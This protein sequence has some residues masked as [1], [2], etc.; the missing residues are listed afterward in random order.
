[1]LDA[2]KRLSVD[3]VPAVRHMVA[4]KCTVLWNVERNLMWELIEYFT[5][6]E[7]RLGI[8]HFFLR[9][10]LMGLPSSVR[11]EKDRCIRAVYHRTRKREGSDDIRGNAAWFIVGENLWRKNRRYRSYFDAFAR[12]LVYFHPE[13]SKT[14]E[15]CRDL[16]NFDEPNEGAQE[17]RRIRNWGFTFLS[18]VVDSLVLYLSRAES[19]HS[20]QP[21]AE[22]SED[23]SRSAFEL[24]HKISLRVKISSGAC[25]IIKDAAETGS[26]PRSDE[27]LR[28]FAEE[29]ESL[30][31]RLCQVKYAAIAF[32][33][34]KT[35]RHLS[36]VKPEK[37]LLLAA[38]LLKRSKEDGLHFEEMAARAVVEYV[39]EFLAERRDLLRKKDILHALLDILDIF[40]E[41]GW[42]SAT[43]L[44]YRL[45]EVF[46]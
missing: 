40:V 2:V 6:Q 10:A 18:S 29:S 3:P 25:E 35:L 1:M 22:D 14:I 13:A 7:E 33:I 19:S 26:M 15:I 32:E 9:A 24:L 21:S 28:R 31:E 44:T 41:A 36:Q 11:G 17:C 39:E 5:Y 16:L 42:P 4:Q 45:D 23:A 34:L 43:R 27:Q 30:L 38:R 20:K 46:R 37:M 12:N 8:L